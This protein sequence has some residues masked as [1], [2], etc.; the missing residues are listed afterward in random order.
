MSADRP[1]GLPEK[2]TLV[3]V[4]QVNGRTFTLS[5]TPVA[6]FIDA[7]GLTPEQATQLVG[8]IVVDQMLEQLEATG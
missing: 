1:A 3:F 2:Y 4:D 5:R 8:D 6:T 7:Q